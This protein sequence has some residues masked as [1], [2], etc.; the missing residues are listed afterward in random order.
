MARQRANALSKRGIDW[1]RAA[2]GLALLM[3]AYFTITNHVELYPLN[4]LGPAGSQWPST[5]AGWGL[6]SVFILLMATRRRWATFAA[7]VIAVVWISLQFRQWY[8]PYLFNIGPVDWYFAHGYSETLKVLPP[9]P[10]HDVTPDLQH[11]I[12]QLLSLSVVG[13][14]IM[15]ARQ[16]FRR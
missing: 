8:L 11:N 14:S 10:G 3:L 16:N 6:F 15:A 4:N 12:L 5:L 9:I 7:L 2:I 1:T 13:A